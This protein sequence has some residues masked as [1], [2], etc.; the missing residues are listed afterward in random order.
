MSREKTYIKVPQLTKE[1][2][3]SKACIFHNSNK[4]FM[5]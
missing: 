1:E 5:V 3:I 2:K 4:Y